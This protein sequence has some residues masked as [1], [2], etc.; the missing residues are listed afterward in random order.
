VTIKKILYNKE[1]EGLALGKGFSW[2]W[3][4]AKGH[5]GGGGGDNTPRDK[6][7]YTAS[8][9]LGSGEHFVAVIIKNRGQY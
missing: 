7:R 8:R 6:R 3:V 2:S 9:G 5:S 4:A 1:L